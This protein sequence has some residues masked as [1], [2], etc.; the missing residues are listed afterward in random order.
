[1]MNDIG[2]QGAVL[3][4]G[5]IRQLYLE[6]QLIQSKIDLKQIQPNSLDLTLSGKYKTIHPNAWI[7]HKLVIDPREEMV[8]DDHEFSS[9]PLAI[10]QSADSQLVT[11]ENRWLRIEPNEFLV[12]GT[13]EVLSIPNGIC[14]VLQGRSSIGRMGLQIT[15][16]GFIDSGFLGSPTLQVFNQTQYPIYLFEGM[17]ICQ[18]V[19]YRSSLSEVM[20]GLARRSKYGNS[21]GEAEGSKIADDFKHYRYESPPVMDGQDNGGTQSRPM[22]V[23]FS[24]EDKINDNF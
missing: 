24:S 20:Y 9:E 21:V 11:A 10:G 18:I 3:S 16:A 5:D 17:R 19:F 4:D 15:Q 14:G 23:F 7:Y 8:Y 6:G 12:L 1:M 22:K 13:N 2:I